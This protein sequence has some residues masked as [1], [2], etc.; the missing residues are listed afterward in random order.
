MEL[1]HEADQKLKLTVG[2]EIEL[3]ELLQ[4]YRIR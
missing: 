4:M 2:I 3:E 1:S